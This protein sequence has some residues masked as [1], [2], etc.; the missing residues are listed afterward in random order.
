MWVN[1]LEMQELKKEVENLFLFWNDIKYRRRKKIE[2]KKNEEKMWTRES[3][4]N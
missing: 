3:F 4:E 2:L 1:K